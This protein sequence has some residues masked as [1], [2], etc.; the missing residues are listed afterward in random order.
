MKRILWFSGLL[1]L[2]GGIRLGLGSSNYSLWGTIDGGAGGV[3][4]KQVGYTVRG[5]AGQPDAGIGS[6]VKGVSY[7]VRSGFWGPIAS[8]S[9]ITPTKTSTPN[10]VELTATAG[11]A[12]L[13]PTKLPT[14]KPSPTKTSTPNAVELTATAGGATLT[15]T[16]PPTIPPSPTKIPTPNAVEL[17]ATA[18]GATLTPTKAPTKTPTLNA[19]ELTATAGGATLTPTK[20]PT[21]KPS[22]TKNPTPNA[23]ELTATAG[24]ATL[25][26]TKAPTKTPTLNAVELTATAGGATLTPTKAPTRTPLLTATSIPISTPIT[27]CLLVSLTINHATGRPGSFFTFNL[28]STCSLVPHEIVVSKVLTTGDELLFTTF[29]ITT[30]K[31]GAVKFILSTTGASTGKYKVLVKKQKRNLSSVPESSLFVYLTLDDQ[32]PLWLREADGVTKNNEFAWPASRQL[33]IPFIM[34]RLLPLI[35]RSLP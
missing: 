29:G 8:T 32:A 13:T 34:R 6:S 22:P 10:V 23:V 14:V 28:E 30:S 25:T 21:A 18:G 26:P 35:I 3:G 7:E 12:T 11:G 20:L 2:L 24:G 1:L 27:T 33:F 16:K 15:P 5:S 4:R 17:T 9:M 19:V 31:Q